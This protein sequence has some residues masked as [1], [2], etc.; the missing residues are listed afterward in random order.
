MTFKLVRFSINKE[1]EKVEK[2]EF[3]F[4]P[5]FI[6]LFHVH[7][8]QVLIIEIISFGTIDHHNVFENISENSII[9]L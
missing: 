9:N 1:D 7:S 4:I 8:F 6:K 2:L 3:C 5:I